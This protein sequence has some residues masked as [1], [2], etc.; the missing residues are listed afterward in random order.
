MAVIGED[1]IRKQSINLQKIYLMGLFVWPVQALVENLLQW[2]NPRPFSA[3]STLLESASRSLSIRGLFYG[4]SLQWEGGVRWSRG[5]I[6][7][8]LYVDS[9]GIQQSD[10]NGSS[11]GATSPE[12]S[13]TSG[14]VAVRPLQPSLSVDD[15]RSLI[16]RKK[17]EVAILEAALEILETAPRDKR[18][19]DLVRKHNLQFDPRSSVLGDLVAKP[20]IELEPASTVEPTSQMT[21]SFKSKNNIVE[22]NSVGLEPA[23]TSWTVPKPPSQKT[24]S[25]RMFGKLSLDDFPAPQDPNLERLQKKRRRLELMKEYERNN[26]IES[27]N[28]GAAARSAV[29]GSKPVSIRSSILF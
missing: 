14:S 15:F 23:K 22:N 6:S 9:V 12:C 24:D 10:S 3:G 18:F 27:L 20:N 28:L 19:E 26:K 25:S 16:V 8:S 13:Y 7:R 29:G 4:V 1:N 21:D 2:R 5:L 17:S 11:G